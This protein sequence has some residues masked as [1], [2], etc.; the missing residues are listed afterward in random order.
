MVKTINIGDKSF[1]LVPFDLHVHGASLLDWAKTQLVSPLDTLLK[2]LDRLPK[3]LQESLLKDALKEDRKPLSWDDP[4][5]MSLLSTP[6]GVTKILAIRLGVPEDEVAAVV[7]KAQE[8]YGS[9]A[10]ARMLE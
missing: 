9:E 2:K 3:H 6:A 4:A 1:T 8:E 7:T 10:F 5:V